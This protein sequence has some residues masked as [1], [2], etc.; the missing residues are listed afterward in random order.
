[1][2][3]LATILLV[4]VADRHQ[5]RGDRLIEFNEETRVWMT[6]EEA[7]KLEPLS[8]NFM[9]VTHFQGPVPV[10][11]FPFSPIPTKISHKAL[12]DKLI[13]ELQ[14]HHLKDQIEKLSSYHTRYYNSDTGKEAATHLFKKYQEYAGDRDDITVEMFA[15]PNMKQFSVIAKIIGSGDEASTRIIVGGHL[16]SIGTSSTG[17]APGADDD[18]SGSSTVLEVFRVLAQ[19][20]FKPNRTLEFHAYAAEEGG[21]IGSQYIAKDYNA[22][23]IVV[24]SML[25]LDM[26]MYDYGQ[27][28]QPIAIITDYTSADLNKFL[29]LLIGSYSSLNTVNSRC[30]YACSDHASWTKYGYRSAFPFEAPMG[31]DDPYIHTSQDVIAHLDLK[32]GLEFAKFVLGYSIEMS[33]S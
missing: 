11:D 4:V 29:L 9:D 19:S 23:G 21:L 1:L 26:N 24:E 12:V 16:D 6:A 22:L 18:A 2:V 8:E 33:L 5:T 32:K 13:P 14:E 15:H 25:Q 20:G 30:G 17:R 10:K 27:G 7:L 3:L 31:D 28:Q